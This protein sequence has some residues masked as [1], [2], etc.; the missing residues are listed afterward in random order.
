[1]VVAEVGDLRDV[2]FRDGIAETVDESEETDSRI[3][4][5]SV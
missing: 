5:R 1:M 4:S 2:D 3:M